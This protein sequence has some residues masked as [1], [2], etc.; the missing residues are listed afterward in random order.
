MTR[1]VENVIVSRTSFQPV[2]AF[3]LIELLVV[4]SIVA[5]LISIL[6][7]ALQSARAAGRQAVCL[8]QQRQI[9]QMLQIYAMDYDRFI[10]KRYDPN[11]DTDTRYWQGR[12]IVPGLLTDGDVLFCPSIEPTSM[13]A[14]G[15]SSLLGIARS[16]RA[17]IYGMRN[18]LDPALSDEDPGQNGENF[19][20]ITKLDVIEQP[21]DFFL[22]ADSF[23]T[24]FGNPGYQLGFNDTTRNWRLHL[25]HGNQTANAVFADGHATAEDRSYFESLTDRQAEYMDD[26]SLSLW[27]SS[28]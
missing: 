5:L 18:W 17:E 3:S 19:N 20:L 4:I 11:D 7:P 14:S 2:A 6:L 27:P 8:S 15:R 1:L 28:P 10:P 22:I 12:L 25:R 24:L 23:M 13:A 21:A 26:H 9:G 16:H